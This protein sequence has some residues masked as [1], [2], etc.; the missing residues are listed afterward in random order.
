MCGVVPCRQVER[1]VPF[2]LWKVVVRGE[3]CGS[4]EGRGGQSRNVRE[5]NSSTLQSAAE[6][7]RCPPAVPGGLWDIACILC[8]RR[9]GRSP[10]PCWGAGKGLGHSIRGAGMSGG[11]LNGM[12]SNSS[13][14]WNGGW[15]AASCT[16]PRGVCSSPGSDM[17][18]VRWVSRTQEMACSE[19]GREG[20]DG[21]MGSRQWEISLVTG[22]PWC[23]VFQNGRFLGDADLERQKYPD[24]KLNGPQVRGLSAARFPGGGSRAGLQCPHPSWV[25]ATCVSNV[26]A[27]A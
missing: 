25:R 5:S 10:G 9:C 19:P 22:L 7:P 14:G 11:A 21:Y 17:W 15:F 26:P 20:V 1:Q 4:G 27:L 6:H 12:S 23:S 16:D 2:C 13:P 24:L 18:G 3:T 8:V